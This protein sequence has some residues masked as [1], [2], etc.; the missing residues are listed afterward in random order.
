MPSKGQG[1][2]FA[3]TNFSPY[4]KVVYLALMNEILLKI[5]KL[6]EQKERILVA[7]DGFGGAGKSS[8]ARALIAEIGGARHIEFDWFHFPRDQVQADIRF[9]FERFKEEVVNPF[10]EGSSEL[11]IR[12]YNWGYLADKPEE[13]E[14]DSV[15][16]GGVSILIVEGV[17]TL[18]EQ[19]SEVIDL[20][21]WVGADAKE[22]RKRGIKR[23]I[24]EYGLK[25]ENVIPAWKE[26]AD[27]EN[28]CLQLDD[29]RKR[30]DL[31]I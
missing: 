14:K 8:L 6:R 2:Q 5:A 29:R 11:Q 20:K 4:L 10:Y 9:D 30:A 15:R 16:L 23:D 1:A 25:E 24:H 26:W 31:V 17:M 27:W 21:I 7:I 3:G 13:L 28:K 12:K 18:H 19:L 22:S